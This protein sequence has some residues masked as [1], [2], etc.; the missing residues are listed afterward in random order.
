M[1]ELVFKQQKYCRLAIP[2]ST[3]IIEDEMEV[4]IVQG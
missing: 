3:I 1:D 4:V 2:T